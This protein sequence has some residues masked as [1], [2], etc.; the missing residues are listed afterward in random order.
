MSKEDNGLKA[1]AMAA[2]FRSAG[3]GALQPT[4]PEIREHEGLKYVVLENVNGILAVYRIRT[5]NG[6]P[7]LKGLKRWPKEVAAAA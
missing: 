6:A 2:Y 5:V 4:A 7:V 3:E 1:R